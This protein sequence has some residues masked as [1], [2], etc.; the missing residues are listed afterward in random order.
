MTIAGGPRSGKTEAL[1]RIAEALSGQDGLEVSLVLAGVRPEEIAEA[2]S[3][4]VEPVAAL[5]F[6]VGADPQGQAVERVAKRD[7]T[8]DYVAAEARRDGSG[9]GCGKASSSPRRSIG[10]PTV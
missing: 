5:S 3:G 8:L 9:S 1:R 4:P 6:A 10:P 2:K 7:E